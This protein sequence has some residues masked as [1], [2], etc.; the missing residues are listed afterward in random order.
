MNHKHGGMSL[1]E[2]QV[3]IA[4]TALLMS[5]TGLCLHGL[6]R[7]H[8]VLQDGLQRQSSIDR[9]SRQFR[10]DVHQA[11]RAEV[12]AAK[13]TNSVRL[14]HPDRAEWTYEGTDEGVVRVTRLAGQISHRDIFRISGGSLVSWQVANRQAAFVRMQIPRNREDGGHEK[15]N[16]LAVEATVGIHAPEG[17]GDSH[18]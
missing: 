18:E 6:F 1:I 9:L 17:A 11:T 3:V 16:W 8:A 5:G 13:G 7:T 14:I 2:T 10:A 15:T 4:I 12:N